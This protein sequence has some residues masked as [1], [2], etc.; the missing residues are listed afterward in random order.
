[1]AE[2]ESMRAR[3]RVVGEGPGIFLE[4]IPG[5]DQEEVTLITAGGEGHWSWC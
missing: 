1:M 4:R 2:D 3:A 5:G